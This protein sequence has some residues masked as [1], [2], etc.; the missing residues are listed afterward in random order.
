MKESM[1][2]ALLKLVKK[3]LGT[4]FLKINLQYLLRKEDLDKET[5]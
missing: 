4:D 3:V 1:E 2:L 5:R